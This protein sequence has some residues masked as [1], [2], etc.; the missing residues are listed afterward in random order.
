VGSTLEKQ[1]EL[2]I[3]RYKDILLTKLSVRDFLQSPLFHMVEYDS[4][5]K[6]QLTLR[7]QL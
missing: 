7:N 5:I 1:R 2:N 3:A 4:F 6:S